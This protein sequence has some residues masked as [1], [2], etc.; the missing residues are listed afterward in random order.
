MT[1][2]E[3]RDGVTEQGVYWAKW[4]KLNVGE[5]KIKDARKFK[6]G[7]GGKAGAP[8]AGKPGAPAAGGTAKILFGK[9]A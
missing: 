6:A 3:A 2:A 9:K 7:A 1:V 5:G 4:E 8:A